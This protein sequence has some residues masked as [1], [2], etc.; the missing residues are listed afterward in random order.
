MSAIT[1]NNDNNITFTVTPV[2]IVFSLATPSIVFSIERPGITVG[3]INTIE[4]DQSPQEITFNQTPQEIAFELQNAHTII[5]AGLIGPSGPPGED[6]AP[7]ADGTPGADGEKGDKGDQGVQ[8]IQG[9]QGLKGD[10]GE[11]GA[12][13]SQGLKGDTGS[14]GDKGDTGTDGAKG[15]TGPQGI[16]G[17]KGEDGSSVTIKGSVATSGDLPIVGN[18]VGDGYIVVADSCLYVCTGLPATF[19]NVGVIVGPQGLPGLQG[20]KGDTGP[21]AV[22]AAT[23]TNYSGLLKGDGANF[24]TVPDN[25]ANWNT[26]YSWGDH[27]SYGYF[28]K[29]VDT[30]DNITAGTTNVHLTDSLRT[31]YNAAVAASHSAITLG[32]ANGLSLATQQI[33]LGLSSTITT[34]ALSSSDWNAFNSKQATLTKSIFGTTNQIA[35]SSNTNSV[36]VDV[37]LSLP[38]NIHTLATPQFN[39]LGLGAAASPAAI[40]YVSKEFTPTDGTVFYSGA[41]FIPLVNFPSA[42]IVTATGTYTGIGGYV[43]F[44]GSKYGA[45]SGVWGLSFGTYALGG[46]LS[47][48]SDQLSTYGAEIFGVGGYNRNIRVK[49][50]A[51]M[52]VYPVNLTSASLNVVEY[53]CGLFVDT[54]KTYDSTYNAPRQ[55][56]IYVTNL[57]GATANYQA[58]L[59]GYGTG[60]GL[61]FNAQPMD[62]AQQNYSRLYSSG[63]SNLSIEIDSSGTPATVW[64]INST[65]M[66][67][68]G[69]ATI[70]GTL[71]VTGITSLTGILNANGGITVDATNFTVSGTTG[72][73][74]TAGDFDVATN[75]FL[76]AAATG[77]TT[78][79]GTLG[80]TGNVGIG[81]TN[82]GYTLDVQAPNISTQIKSTTGTNAAYTQWVNNGVF[83][84]GID[85]FDGGALAN[86]TTGY[87]GVIN[88]VG[89]N[90]LHFATNNTVRATIDSGGNVGIGTA[91][92]RTSLEVTGAGL[93]TGTQTPAPGIPG[94]EVGY[95]SALTAGYILAYERG[96]SVKP[97]LINPTGGYVG[98]GTTN[99]GSL[100]ELGSI[101]DTDIIR[102]RQSVNY[103][104]SISSLMSATAGLSYLAFNINN[105][106]GVITNNA[107]IFRGSGNVLDVAGTSRATNIID[108]GLTASQL[109]CTDANKQ[110]VSVLASTLSVS[111]AA[112]SGS[113]SAVAWS[114]VSGK[115]TTVSGY[116]ITDMSSQSVSYA[117][118]SGSASDIHANVLVE[119]NGGFMVGSNG[120][121]AA[122]NN[123]GYGYLR[124]ILDVADIYNEGSSFGGHL[125]VGGLMKVVGEVTIGTANQTGYQFYVT[126][127]SYIDGSLHVSAQL[128]AATFFC[129]AI[130]GMTV[131]EGPFAGN[132][133]I[134]GYN[135]LSNNSSGIANTAVGI[136]SLLSSVSVGRNTAVGAN[137]LYQT[138]GGYNT[139]VGLS[140][141][142]GL[143]GGSNCSFFGNDA[144]PSSSSVSN[145]ITLGNSSVNKLRCQVIFIT[146]LSDERDKAD[147]APL[148]CGLDFINS[149]N[150]ASFTWNMRDGAKVGAKDC[151]FIAQDLQRAQENFNA[152]QYLDLVYAENPDKLEATPGRLLPVMVNA[153]KEL[154]LKVDSLNERLN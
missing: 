28:K 1:F 148:P 22:T 90:S 126:G 9:V 43:V 97:L 73:V 136:N 113:A 47:A 105:G 17:D 144:Q 3:E 141:G 91:S 152:A 58:A 103:Y 124:G 34:G 10:T 82:P 41:N 154:S 67:L 72:A 98:I 19:V 87:S 57:D 14:K 119:L 64:S 62:S 135:A 138:T 137:S 40:I 108:T 131:G 36:A 121:Y 130:N 54:N 79:A 83:V 68:T 128:S 24:S 114:G 109:V 115:P 75:K 133:T 55:F 69:N 21:N 147:I 42:G 118:T 16:Q 142:Y 107:V 86:G 117:A 7:G 151:G 23:T 32:T 104:H 61:W 74:H 143:Y 53:A 52:L 150:P 51:G 56:G 127:D 146:A 48:G 60:T 49:N 140:A 12:D 77:N 71:V 5:Y 149:L 70:S 11:K 122:I 35:V 94:V 139:A 29:S 8:G 65:T 93:F 96:V 30:L 102:L 13:G 25:S 50:T 31:S 106:S 129:V 33:S 27:S 85:D 100:L 15:D 4:F 6:G 46:E 37:T 44:R 63:N 26:S 76:V 84:I 110:L 120:Y 101:P 20:V 18:T 89:A 2:E 92:P 81:T 116:G 134:V 66:A 112:T 153:I 132:N 99:P 38:Q 45:G 125:H 39:G 95:L 59:G 80:V 78:V 123:L 145:E 88:R 111:Y